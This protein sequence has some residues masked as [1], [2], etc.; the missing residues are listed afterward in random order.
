MIVNLQLKK[1]REKESFVIQELM[2][3]TDSELFRYRPGKPDPFISDRYRVFMKAM[4]TCKN[5]GEWKAEDI[6]GIS[7]PTRRSI[8]R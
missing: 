1:H 5:V 3:P 6:P 7:N 4:E 2:R 8:C